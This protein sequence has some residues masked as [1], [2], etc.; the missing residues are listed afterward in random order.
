MTM[1]QQQLDQR[2]RYYK[3][4]HA[5]PKQRLRQ[6]LETYVEWPALYSDLVDVLFVQIMNPKDLKIKDGKL[7]DTEYNIKW[8]GV[9]PHSIMHHSQL[10]LSFRR[11]I[12]EYE[13]P[14]Y[15]LISI[16]KDS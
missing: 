14:A 12:P 7:G 16:P 6:M 9:S 11:A 10:L 1:T 4:V 3:L 5:V 2:L 13:L 15:V 8:I